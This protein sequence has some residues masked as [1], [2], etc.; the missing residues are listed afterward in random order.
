MNRPEDAVGRGGGA[1]AGTGAGRAETVPVFRAFLLAGLSLPV[2][3]SA[4]A[5]LLSGSA[6]AALLTAAGALCLCG[7]AAGA[8][9]AVLAARTGKTLRQSLAAAFG[10]EGR[11][12]GRAAR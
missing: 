4:A 12:S 2:L 5:V 8:G 7:A 6:S 3:G 11:H 10:P 1:D 9:L